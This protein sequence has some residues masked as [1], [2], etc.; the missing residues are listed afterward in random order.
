MLCCSAL[1]YQ[2]ADSTCAV[3]SQSGVPVVARRAS[4]AVEAAG[5]VQ[6]VAALAG[7]FI[8]V[9]KNQIWV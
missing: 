4:F 5:V 1:L 6:A 7:H 8:T 3:F 9:F 2:T